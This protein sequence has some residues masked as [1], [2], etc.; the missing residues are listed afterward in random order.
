MSIDKDWPVTYLWC[1]P[2]RLSNS[3]SFFLDRWKI[4]TMRAV[5]LSFVFPPRVPST[6]P[7]PL[8]AVTLQVLCC[9]FFYHCANFFAGKKWRKLK[10][11]AI[12]S[13]SKCAIHTVMAFLLLTVPFPEF[14]K[15]KKKMAKK[16]R[17][18]TAII[19]KSIAIQ[20]WGCNDQSYL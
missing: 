7:F 19:F 5:P 8:W 20:D 13:F 10:W 4:C 16:Y 11:R 1:L 17:V 6:L 18:S 15:S 9:F 12:L 14:F 3:Q 2:M